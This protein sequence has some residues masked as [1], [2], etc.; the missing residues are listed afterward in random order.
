MNI[1]Y[2]RI[3]GVHHYIIEI[4]ASKLKR[5][6]NKEKEKLQALLTGEPYEPCMG[7]EPM[8]NQQRQP[9]IYLMQELYIEQMCNVLHGGN[10][11]DTV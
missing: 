11:N 9:H 8:T 3:E 6:T 4:E 10:S 5:F 1:L 2:F 7:Y